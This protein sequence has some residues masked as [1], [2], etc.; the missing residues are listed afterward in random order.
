MTA[1]SAISA[2]MQDTNYSLGNN[3]RVG[4]LNTLNETEKE[5]MKYQKSNG[6]RENYFPTKLKKDATSDCVIR[7]IA[8]ATGLDYM[9][10]WNDLF[11][12]G[13]EIGHLPNNKKCYEAY[14][15][16]LGWEKF[17][18][19]KVNNK[20]V[21]VRNFPAKSNTSYMIHTTNHVTAIVNRVHLDSWN[22]GEWCAN[23]FYMKKQQGV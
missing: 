1:S 15:E 5:T 18:P 3:P 14:L 7:A 4:C 11:D 23:S 19:V 16:T 6:G 17:S 12:L 20:K 2:D 13:R 10:V 9:K 22:C 21:Q 8:I